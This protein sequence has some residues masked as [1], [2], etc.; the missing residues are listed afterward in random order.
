VPIFI[1][2]VTFPPRVPRTAPTVATTEV[3]A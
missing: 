3:L 2:L 1:K